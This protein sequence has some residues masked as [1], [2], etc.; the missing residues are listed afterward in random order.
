[1][2]NQQIPSSLG[3]GAMHQTPLPFEAHNK[4]HD[5]NQ[6]DNVLSMQPL[7]LRPQDFYKGKYEHHRF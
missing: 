5:D 3:Y 2:K 7:A 4:D 1:M 6:L